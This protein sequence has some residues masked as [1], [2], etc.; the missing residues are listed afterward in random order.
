MDYGLWITVVIAN[1]WRHWVREKWLKWPNDIFKCIFLNEN[2]RIS[3]K[4]SLKF[5]P[6]AP[7]DNMPSLVQIMAWRQSGD[8]SLSETMMVSLHIYASL[9]INELKPQQ[10]GI[11]RHNFDQQLMKHLWGSICGRTNRRT[12]STKENTI[13]NINRATAAWDFVRPDHNWK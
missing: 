5:V 9:D 7:I 2:I 10:H 8:K 1:N 3:I 12:S 11:N 4:I 6:N 13:L